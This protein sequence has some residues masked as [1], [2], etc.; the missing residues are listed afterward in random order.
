LLRELLD[1]ALSHG[2]YE[3]ENPDEQSDREDDRCDDESDG[4]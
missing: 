2:R 3:P 4:P 1:R